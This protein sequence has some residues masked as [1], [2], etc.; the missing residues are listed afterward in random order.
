MGRPAYNIR[1]LTWIARIL[2]LASVVGIFISSYIFYNPV[3]Y[4]FTVSGI[5]QPFSQAIFYGGSLLVFAG[6]MWLWPGASSIIA[7]LWVFFI[8]MREFGIAQT[9]LPLYFF[10]LDVYSR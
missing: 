6:F 1:R 4:P 5:S 7:L 10:L 8:F 9:P 3:Y 2:V